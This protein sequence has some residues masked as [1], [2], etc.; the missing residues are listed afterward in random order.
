MSQVN[1]QPFLKE[2]RQSLKECIFEAKA[3]LGPHYSI[4]TPLQLVK[5]IQDYF[6]RWH[7]DRVAESKS[8]EQIGRT[9]MIF[10]SL[11]GEQLVKRLAW[12]WALIR[13]HDQSFMFGVVSPDRSLVTYPFESIQILMNNPKSG[14]DL[15]HAFRFLIDGELPVTKPGSYTTVDFSDPTVRER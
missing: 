12:Q 6:H 8:D 1:E 14:L 5:G 13:F 4:A 7:L 10:G 15:V 11:W 2:H 9:Q 3:L